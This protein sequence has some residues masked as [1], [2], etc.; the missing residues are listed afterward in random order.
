MATA[1]VPANEKLAAMLEEAAA[2]IRASTIPLDMFSVDPSGDLY[3]H[4][5]PEFAVLGDGFIEFATPD[6]GSF[7][8]PVRTP[9]GGVTEHRLVLFAGPQT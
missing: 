4:V 1:A 5:T 2:A 6:F 3:R 9:T 8:G 7:H